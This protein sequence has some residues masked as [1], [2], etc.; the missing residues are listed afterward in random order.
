MTPQVRRRKLVRVM[1]LWCGIIKPENRAEVYAAD[2]R[3]ATRHME[4]VEG[5][6][7]FDVKRGVRRSFRLVQ[8]TTGPRTSQRRWASYWES[9]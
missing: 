8:V 4:D 3:R 6:P 9:I 7:S 1:R 2:R 5:R